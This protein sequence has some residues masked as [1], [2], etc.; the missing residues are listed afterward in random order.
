MFDGGAWGRLTA[1]FNRGLV[2][3]MVMTMIDAGEGSD[4]G[5]LQTDRGVE[6]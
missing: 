4:S 3:D 1:C 6:Q 5:I 2:L